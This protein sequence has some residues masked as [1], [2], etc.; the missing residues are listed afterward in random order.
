MN[1]TDFIEALADKMGVSRG[2]ADKMVNA[3]VDLVTDS[4]TKEEDVNITGF[5]NF[6]VSHRKAR[7]GVNPQNPSEKIHIAATRV[8]KF[9]A[10]KALKDAVKE[11]MPAQGDD[12]EGQV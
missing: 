2:E 12:D 5:G 6:T 9:K 7:M 4:L 8:P 1:K 11:S 10:G 3:F